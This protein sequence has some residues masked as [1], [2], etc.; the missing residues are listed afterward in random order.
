MAEKEE[1][2]YFK[3]SISQL[4]T[5]FEQLK[6]N[7]DSLK[8]LDYELSFR[9]TNRA[10]KL[11]LRIAEVLVTV[12]FKQV[13]AAVADG[14]TPATEPGRKPTPAQEQSGPSPKTPVPPPM[15]LGELPSI[16]VPQNANQ[17]AAILAAWTAL[18]ALS[19]QTYS[20]PEA[21]GGWRP[22]LCCQSID[23]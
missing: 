23:R 7:P 5:L 10:A 12:S 22:E 11:R 8:V 20:R 13:N 18:E 9:T 2:P 16:L 14:A 4:E 21:S 17:P 19:P 3:S 6:A 1:R 15:D